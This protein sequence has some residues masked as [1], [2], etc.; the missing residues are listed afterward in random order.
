MSEAEVIVD[1]KLPVVTIIREFDAPPEKV[2]RA[3]VEPEL[4]ARWNYPDGYDIRFDRF[5]CQTGGSYRIS[6]SG[7]DIEGSVYGSFHEVIPNEL[8][9]QTF[10]PDGAPDLIVLETHRFEAISDDRTRL[11]AKSLVDSFEYRDSFIQAGL[12]EGYEKL[13]ELL[14]EL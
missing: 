9:V 7:G 13:D 12:L 2:F 11:T 6:M 5:D 8:I 10:S 1:E 14:A 3:H 4:F